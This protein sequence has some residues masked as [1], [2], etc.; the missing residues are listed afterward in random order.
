MQLFIWI[1]C[2]LVT[3]VSPRLELCSAHHYDVA[4]IAVNRVLCKPIHLSVVYYVEAADKI[5]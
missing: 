2:E 1:F 4:E 5:Q 3:K